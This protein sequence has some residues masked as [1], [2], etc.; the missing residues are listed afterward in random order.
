[1]NQPSS[2][3]HFGMPGGYGPAGYNTPPGAGEYPLP[4]RAGAPRP[5]AP[6]K[7]RGKKE[8]QP[9]TSTKRLLNKQKVFALLFALVAVVLGLQLSANP[10][11]ETFVIRTSANIPA[12]AK[13]EDSQYEI[14]SLPEL[15]IEEG[16]ISASSEEDVRTLVS[17]LL[18]NGRTRMALPKGHQLHKDD[19]SLDAS[20]SVPL[21]ANERILA[22]EAN[23][24]AAIGGQL[25]AGDRVDVIAVIDS[26]GRTISNMVAANVEI[27]ST[28][29]GQQQFDTAAQE[30]SSGNLDKSGNELL[31]DD[32][33]PGIYN[34]RVNIDQAV[35][36]A[37]AQSK[38]ELVLVLRGSAATDQSTT[39]PVYLEDVITGTANTPS[40]VGG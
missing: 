16:A 31:P 38:G 9:K 23:V 5:D 3:D 17:E 12:L 2:G 14:I 22:V 10:T 28:L 26:Q 29:P 15:A 21:A 24:V 19:F 37:A 25:K 30:Q 8:K 18:A 1:M 39:N 35:L 7:K 11:P 33:V 36:L 40:T 32:P 34:V 4:Q 27:I 6:G 20:L 13:I